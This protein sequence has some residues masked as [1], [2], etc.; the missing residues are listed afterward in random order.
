[1]IVLTQLGL[2]Q[3]ATG[4][5]CPLLQSCGGSKKIDHLHMPLKP[6]FGAKYLMM[7]VRQGMN[8]LQHVA[9]TWEVLIKTNFLI[10]S[11]NFRRNNW[12]M[13]HARSTSLTMR[14]PCLQIGLFVHLAH[15]SSILHL[16]TVRLF[17]WL[18]RSILR[19][20]ERLQPGWNHVKHIHFFT[21]ILEQA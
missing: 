5:H 13:W 9:T 1:M 16:R 11:S 21:F 14:D 17:R 7:R 4:S 20:C 19:I 8:S 15:H 2:I 18:G 6:W 3:T 12:T 10:R